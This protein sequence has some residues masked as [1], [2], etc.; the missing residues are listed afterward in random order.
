MKKIAKEDIWPSTL[1]ITL[2]MTV[3]ALFSSLA[4]AIKIA[5]AFLPN[6]EF[7]TFILMFSIVFLQLQ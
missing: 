3:I 5:F 2:K 7:V 1:K 4:L 6:V